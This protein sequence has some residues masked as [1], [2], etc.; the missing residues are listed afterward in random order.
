MVYIFICF[1]TVFVA[2]LSPSLAFYQNDDVV[3]LNAANFDRLV[4]RGDEI[5]IG[6]F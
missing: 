4:V 6:N 2:V 1:L 5:W 3:E